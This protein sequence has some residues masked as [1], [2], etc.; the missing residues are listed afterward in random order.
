MSGDE[1][2]KGI[3]RADEAYDGQVWNV[4]GHRY[5]C[6]AQGASTFAWLSLDPR[7]AACRRTSTRRRTSS[8]T[9]WR[10][11]TRS[12]S[13]GSGRRRVP[14]TW[15]GCRAASRTRTT[16]ARTTEARS[17]FWVSPG[18]RLA[19]L[20]GLL[21]DLDDVEEV[22]RLSAAARRR[23]PPAGIRRGCVATGPTRSRRSHCGPAVRG[24]R[25]SSST[26]ATGGRA[27]R[28][29]SCCRSSRRCASVAGRWRTS[30]TG[31]SAPAAAGPRRSRTPGPRS[32]SCGPRHRGPSCSS[33]I[34][35]AASSR[36]CTRA[37]PTPW[38][39]SH[40]S[41]TSCAASARESARTRSSPSWAR[42]PTRT[43]RRT[44]GVAAGVDAAVPGAR[45]AR[46]GRRARARGAHARLR[47][48]GACGGGG[49][50]AARASRAGAPRADRSGPHWADVHD[51]GGEWLSEAAGRTP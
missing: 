15:C 37:G 1:L 36:C 41:P 19:D 11:P 30:S 4:L 18:G 12:T 21:H 13:T 22:V 3:T 38:S 40:R 46:R 2:A 35:W 50:H 14:A 51:G 5:L 10:G 7:A 48:P 49:D 47:R 23:L 26:A 43:Q 27:T 44:R 45:R 29:T 16:T 28:P 39:R 17:V 6:K 33:V 24:A 34:R 42:R 31:A 8:S 9:S 25:S 32:T 20:F